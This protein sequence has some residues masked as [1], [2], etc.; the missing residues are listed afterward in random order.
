MTLYFAL[1]HNGQG[2]AFHVM[3]HP[4]RGGSGQAESCFCSISLYPARS[5][6]HHFVAIHKGGVNIFALH[7]L[8]TLHPSQCQCAEQTGIVAQRGFGYGQV[9]QIMRMENLFAQALFKRLEQ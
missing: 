1:S 4:L 9:I 3:R 5:A 8:F 7:I 2:A 6:V